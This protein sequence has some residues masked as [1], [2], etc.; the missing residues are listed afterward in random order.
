MSLGGITEVLTVAKQL[1]AATGDAGRS[2][3][4][5]LAL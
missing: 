2:R 3:S 4:L 1:L 5:L